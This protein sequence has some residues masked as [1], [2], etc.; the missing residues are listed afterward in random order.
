MYMVC[1]VM[2]VLRTPSC[3]KT[4]HYDSDSSHVL[5]I[6]LN[7]ENVPGYPGM[8]YINNLLCMSCTC[9]CILILVLDA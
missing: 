9:V 6:F 4:T 7:H 3:L 8:H 2:C 1:D 5:H